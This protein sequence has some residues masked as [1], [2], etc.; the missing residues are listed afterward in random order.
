MRD[1]EIDNL[2]PEP[3]PEDPV[4]AMLDRL[5]S[6]EGFGAP[7]EAPPPSPALKRRELDHLVD[8]ILDD[9]L[10]RLSERKG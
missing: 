6:V 8:Q 7:E 4:T 1:D 3:P 2:I 10:K 5:D 9:E